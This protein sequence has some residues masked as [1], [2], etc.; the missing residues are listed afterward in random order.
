VL[1]IGKQLAT[2]FQSCVM[3][4]EQLATDWKNWNFDKNT[5]YLVC[6]YSKFNTKIPL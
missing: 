4:G 3:I 5:S 6:K 1:V 2:F